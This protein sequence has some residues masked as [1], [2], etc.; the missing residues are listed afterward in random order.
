MFVFLPFTRCGHTEY[1]AFMAIPYTRETDCKIY[2]IK[3]TQPAK[4]FSRIDRELELKA[5][6]KRAV[7]FFFSLCWLAV[8]I[9]PINKS[10]N[11]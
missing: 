5:S 6:A 8:C 1:I 4:R 9:E 11:A 3:N 7:Q 10:D 2:R